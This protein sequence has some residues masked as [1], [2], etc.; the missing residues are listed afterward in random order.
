MSR[1]IQSITFLLV[2]ALFLVGYSF[3]SAQWNPPTAT[4]P[5]DNTPQPVNVGTTTQSKSGNLAA[6]SFAA[7]TE[8]RSNRYCDALGGNCFAATAVGGG[9]GGGITQL[10]GGAGITLSPTTITSSGTISINASYTQRRITGTC[11]AGQAI[12]TVNAD[13]TVVCQTLAP[14]CDWNGSTYSQGARCRTGSL[15]CVS[16]MAGY[17]YQ[18]CGS[19]G[20]WVT[21]G[22]GC[23]NGSGSLTSC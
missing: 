18:T 22:T 15:S 17:T 9:G 4:A 16:G 2:A 20:T 8:M 23:T 1:S 3:M 6:N 13:G 5:G 10:I 21:G 19:D 14:T 7:T 12:R 11:P